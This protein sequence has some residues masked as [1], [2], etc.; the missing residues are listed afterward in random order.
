[1]RN[2]TMS[3]KRAI[4]R[5]SRRRIAILALVACTLAF[6]Q[7]VAWSSRETSS[8]GPA[9]VRRLTESQYRASVADI[10]A[11]DIPVVGRF[12]R[13]LRA[14]GLIAVGTSEAGISSF[15]IEQYDASARGIAAAVVSPERRNQSLPC[16]PQVETVFDKACA[17]QVIE[18]YGPSL[19]RRPLTTQEKKSFVETVRVG[20]DRLGNFYRGLELALAGLMVKPDFLLRIERIE[21]DSRRAGEHRLDEYSKAMRLSYFLT[22]STPDRELL[23]AAGAGELNNEASLKR[24]VD[25]LMASPRFEGAVRAFFEDMLEFEKF[26][27]VAKD[28]II[29]PVYNSVVAADAQEQTLRTITDHLLT[30]KGDYRD[31]FT[32]QS[33]FLTRALGRVYK[34]PVAT[35]NDWEP[36]EFAAANGQSGIL[37]NV[38]FLALHSHPGR[39]SPTLRGKAIREVFMCQKV[40]DPPPDVDFSAVDQVVNNKVSPTARDRLDEHQTEPSCTTC[41]KSIDPLGLTLENFDGAGSF[42]AAENG[43]AIDASGSLDG[44][45]FSG[46]QGLG[47]ALHDNPATTRCLVDKMYRSALG[48]DLAP[49][50]RQYLEDLNQVFAANGYRVPDL[51]RTIALSQMFFAVAAPTDADVRQPMRVSQQLENRS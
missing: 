4:K 37:T 16:Q 21:P 12:E 39:S 47:R 10:F 25:R 22:N 27:D 24:Q 26:D 46:A 50:E 9:V 36:N 29:Y 34:V 11:A 14:D 48:R 18:F 40:P 31:L 49:Q 33:T 43:A 13:E 28:P 45:E 44:I 5:D 7:Q 17:Q 35:R 41:H 23:R 20:H 2:D 6:V 38:S 1:M 3:S 51:M 15:S 8:G 42:R 30:K 19:F 32:T